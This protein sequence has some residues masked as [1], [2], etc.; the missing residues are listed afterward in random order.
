MAD[1][2]TLVLDATTVTLNGPVGGQPVEPTARFV[3]G[4]TVNGTRYAYQKNQI[5]QSIWALQFNDLTAAQKTSLL[6]F[7]QDTAK[8]PTNTFSYTHTDGTAY[9]GVRFAES[10]LQFQRLDSE[11][12]TCQIRLEMAQ[13]IDT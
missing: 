10:V 2:V 13:N 4:K 12:F 3:S 6:T 9:T 7:F 8:G 5:T 11:F 1:T